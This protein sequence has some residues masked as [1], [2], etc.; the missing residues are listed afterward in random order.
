MT[1]GGASFLKPHRVDLL[2]KSGLR[3]N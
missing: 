2:H 3:K 1:T